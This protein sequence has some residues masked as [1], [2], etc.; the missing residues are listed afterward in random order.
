MLICFGEW[1][2]GAKMNLICIGCSTNSHNNDFL[3]HHTLSISKFSKVVKDLRYNQILTIHM[4]LEILTVMY[5]IQPGQ[6]IVRRMALYLYVEKLSMVTW[7]SGS[8]AGLMVSDSH[9][10]G[11]CIE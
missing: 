9:I 11:V 8:D 1:I 2:K 7:L 5:L 10:M 4:S 3:L 6:F